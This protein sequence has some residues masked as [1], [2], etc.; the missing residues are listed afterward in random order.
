VQ[1]VLLDI[2]V[3]PEYVHALM[4]RLTR[5]YEARLDQYEALGILA[6]NNTNDIVGQ[7]GLG[8]TDELPG[9]GF[10]PEHI[11]Y[12]DLWGGGMAQIFSAVSPDAHREFAL[13]YEARC[14][15]RFAL[16]YYGCCEPLHLKVD[17][18]REMLPNVRK[19]SMSPTADAE[20]AAR[21]VGDTLV[22]SAKP[23]PAHVAT[24]EWQPDLVRD[25]LRGILEVTARQG[26]HVELILKDISTVRCEPRRLTEWSA[27]AVE[28][29]EAYSR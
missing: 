8:Y 17:V 26:C 28:V 11:G 20:V 25:E 5:A 12:G 10:D 6:L 3:R 14:L 15:R 24:D 19:I 4:E 16:V 13:H 9:D 2:A 23:N 21:A 22:Y 27:I 7:G 18:T 29:A 1:P